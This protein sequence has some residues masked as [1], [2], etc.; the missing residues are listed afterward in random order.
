MDDSSRG[1]GEGRMHRRT[2]LGRTVLAAVPLA[3]LRF[4]RLAA[5]PPE[6]TGLIPRQKNP[7]NLEF[8]FSTLDSFITPNDRFYVRN[9]FAAPAVEARTWRLKVEGAVKKGL[10]LTQDELRKLPSRSVTATLECAGNG[11]AFL[12][13]KES[14]V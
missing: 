12:M 8:P 10:E 5:A 3:F 9:H 2:F 11:R 4:D 7:D 13:P 6:T 1:R 14:G